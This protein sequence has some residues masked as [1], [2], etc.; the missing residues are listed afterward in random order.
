MKPKWQ[1][2]RIL[3]GVEFPIFKGGELY[4]EIAPAHVCHNGSLCFRSNL[5]GGPT[6]REPIC[7][8]FPH[9]DHR[10]VNKIYIELLP[11]FAEDVP[12]IPWEEFLA[13]CRNSKS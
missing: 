8:V 7:P 11:D 9:D 1:R 2:A 3:N 5:S 13:Q 12:L 6:N 4:V 10:H